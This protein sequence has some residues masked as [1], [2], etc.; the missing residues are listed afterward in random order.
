MSE[1]MITFWR[2]V[3]TDDHLL[4]LVFWNPILAQ[5]GRKQN[6]SRR[7]HPDLT[8]DHVF[9]SVDRRARQ[10]KERIRVLL[11]AD[12]EAG[13]GNALRGGEHQRWARRNLANFVTAGGHDRH[14]IDIRPS[15][16]NG[17]IDFLLLKIAKALGDDFA[18]L[19]SAGDPAE[20]HVDGL[21]A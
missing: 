4:H 16:L 21:E 1:P 13:H 3:R 8:P 6:L 19:V 7:L 12:R 9:W 5:K 18:E 2:H 20:L 17:E 10:R 11:R 14:A 15:R